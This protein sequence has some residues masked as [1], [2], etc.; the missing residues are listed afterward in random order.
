MKKLVQSTGAWSL[1]FEHFRMSKIKKFMFHYEIFCIVFVLDS[2]MTR[3][4]NV[5]KLELQ[6]SV[7]RVSNEL[8]FLLSEMM[9]MY[10]STEVCNVKHLN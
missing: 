4:R 10:F 6:A 1:D 2:W 9:Y 7:F 3:Y 8:K 5:S